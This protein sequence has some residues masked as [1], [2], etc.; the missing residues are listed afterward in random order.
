MVFLRAAVLPWFYCIDFFLSQHNFSG[1]HTRG[2]EASGRRAF[3]KKDARHRWT[4]G[5][6]THF[7]VGYAPSDF[8]SETKMKYR[9]DA[10]DDQ[11]VSPAGWK[12]IVH[13]AKFHHLTHSQ[14]TLDL[15]AA[16]PHITNTKESLPARMSYAPPPKE[17]YNT[18]S[19]MKKDYG[20]LPTRS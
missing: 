20:P 15:K 8:D 13:P 12:E 5:R 2:R 10:K 11:E 14:N 1:M 4:D 17:H 19:I 3:K 16:D 6:S 18:T 7:V 9:G